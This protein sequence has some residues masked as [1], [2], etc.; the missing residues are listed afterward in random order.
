MIGAGGLGCPI[1]S[2]LAAAGVG[3][4]GIIDFDTVDESNLQRQILFSLNDIGTNKARAAKNKL[5]QQNQHINITA[6]DY[7]LTN[8]NAI[9]LFKQFDIIVDGTD[10][11]STRYMVNDACVLTKKPLVYG[12]IYKFEGQV[13]VFN[14]KDGPTYR[15]LFPNPPETVQS[16]SEVGVIGVLPGIIGTQQANEVIKLILGI[17]K[18]MSGR[19]LIY[20]ALEPS[21]FEI[22]ITPSVNIK[23]IGIASISDFESFDYT[24][25]CDTL[26]TNLTEIS[27][28]EFLKI[29]NNVTILDV[30]D[31]WETPRLTS[32]KTVN[33]PLEKI[34]DNI[35]L[36]SK[37]EPVYVL[38]QNGARSLAV[39]NLLKTEF[40]YTNL[41]NVKGGI[42]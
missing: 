37:D 8:L 23:D 12:A 38:C 32:D 7:A 16:C 21:F 20:N 27:K 19:V 36:I 42:Q 33:I 9:E 39:I 22:K 13:S 30:R 3:Q 5:Q 15:C 34:K 31:D 17:G 2:Y 29:Q 18:I 26:D 1:L 41:V 35:K 14:Y 25:S 10:N 11:F 28:S 40:N 6:F 4:I 24:F